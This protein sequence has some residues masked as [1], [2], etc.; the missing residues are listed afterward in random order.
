M[1]GPGNWF[2]AVCVPVAEGCE[3]GGECE[4]GEDY[5]Y[6]ERGRVMMGY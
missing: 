4:R 2:D 1:T 6:Q 3:W 5:I